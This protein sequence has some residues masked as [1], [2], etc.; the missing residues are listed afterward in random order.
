MAVPQKVTFPE[1][2]CHKKYRA[3]LQKEKPKKR[4]QELAGLRGSGLSQKGKEKGS[5]IEEQ[6]LGEEKLLERKR[7][8]LHEWLLREQKTQQEFRIKEKEK[9]ASK[10]QEQ[11]RTLKEQWVKQQ[12]RQREEEDQ[13]RQEKKE[14]AVLK[15]LD[16][17]ENELENGS[18]WQNP[19]PPVDFRVMEKDRANCP[20]CSR[21]G[22]CRF[23]DRQRIH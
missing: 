14:E 23:G 6:Q 15:M 12:R 7:Q 20:F 10:W 17:A 5:F 1:K 11:D 13:K 3:A 2:P 9:A 21:T 19:E 4:W 16:Q 18:T 22:A 8:R